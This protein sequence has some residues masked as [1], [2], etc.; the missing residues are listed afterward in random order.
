M[1]VS[2]SQLVLR[3]SSSYEVCCVSCRRWEMKP[4]WDWSCLLFWA[5][6]L[7]Y[8]LPV[9]MAPEG[10]GTFISK[11]GSRSLHPVSVNAPRVHIVF[12]KQNL[13]FTSLLSPTDNCHCNKS[14]TSR[15]SKDMQCSATWRQKSGM[16]FSCCQGCMHSGRSRRR[17]ADK[18][19]WDAQSQTG[20]LCHTCSPR[21]WGTVSV[22]GPEKLRTR[23]Q[24]KQG[25]S[26]VFCIWQA[27]CIHK[28]RAAVAAC[29]RHAE[30]H[31]CCGIFL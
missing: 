11:L 29:T 6:A 5:Y 13:R 12:Q 22:E 26:S 20:K 9:C 28:L 19:L 4:W 1:P 7:Q 16:R 14:Q 30:D 8:R 10:L 15:V 3:G 18:W 23:N 25:Q 17:I 27:W 2:I 24:G 21:L 31:T